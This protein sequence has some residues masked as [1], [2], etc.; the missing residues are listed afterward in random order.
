MPAEQHV[1]GGVDASLAH[2]LSW[3]AALRLSTGAGARAGDP[4][5]L[6][7]SMRGQDRVMPSRFGTGRLASCL[8]T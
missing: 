3:L 1:S 7:S 4:L 5:V 2:A 8:E 6:G